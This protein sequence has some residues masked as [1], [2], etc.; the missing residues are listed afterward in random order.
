MGW[1]GRRG[2]MKGRGKYFGIK[3]HPKWNFGSTYVSGEERATL[4]G[5]FLS[6]TKWMNTAMEDGMEKGTMCWDGEIGRHEWRG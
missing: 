2:G 6:S 3:Q 1:D 4:A 5:K